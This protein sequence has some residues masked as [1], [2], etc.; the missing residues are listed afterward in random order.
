MN[1][2]STSSSRRERQV[3]SGPKS[4]SRDSGGS[5]SIRKEMHKAT[6]GDC[7]DICEVPFKPNGKKKVLCRDCFKRSD[8]KQ[9]TR[10]PYKSEI[11]FGTK[12]EG[13]YEEQFKALNAKL[14]I[15]IQ[16][17]R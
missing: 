17:L 14:D 3:P 10:S 1:R 6:C 2:N 4:W 15:I 11:K 12:T 16:A 8:D 9:K 13:Q 7:N 5:D